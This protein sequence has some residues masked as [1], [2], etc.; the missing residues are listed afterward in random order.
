MPIRS[1]LSNISG[2]NRYRPTTAE[3]DGAS[4]GSGFSTICG[5]S[6][7]IFVIHRDDA[8]ARRCL[9]RHRFDRDDA[10]TVTVV[11][12]GHLGK[13]TW[14]S[15]NQVIRKVD[16]ERLVTYGRAGA[17]HRMPKAQRLALSYV[18]AGD[19][20]RNDPL[21][22]CQEFFLAGF[23]Q[24]L[25]KLRIGVKMIF[26]CAL[27]ATRHEDQP[28]RTRLYCLFDRVLDQ[29]L[30]DD[31]QHLL[32]ARLGCWQE[33]G[34]PSCDGEHGCSNSLAQLHTPQMRFRLG[35]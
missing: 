4:A 23:D 35:S 28:G 19:T 7:L 8:V 27:R 32:G 6:I 15:G 22:Q 13:A 10:A 33:P 29:R 26:N 11:F 5:D 30:V 20:R 31:W 18:N 34:T 17:Q 9:S 25:L 16:E 14:R 2:L 1:S 12:T 3:F 21:D 24:R